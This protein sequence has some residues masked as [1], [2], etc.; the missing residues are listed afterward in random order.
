MLLLSELTDTTLRYSFLTALRDP[1]H[2]S[3]SD[4]CSHAG[5]VYEDENGNHLSKKHVTEKQEEQA[6]VSLPF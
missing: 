3:P 5:I 2:D 1:F 6:I 4:P